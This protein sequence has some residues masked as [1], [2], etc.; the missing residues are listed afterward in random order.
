LIS[1]RPANSTRP[2]R[3][4]RRKAFQPSLAPSRDQ[5]SVASIPNVMSALGRNS[6][7]LELLAQ[8]RVRRRAGEQRMPGRVDLVQEP[9]LGDLGRPNRTAE[10]VVALEHAHAPPGAREQRAA[11]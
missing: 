4:K 7:T 5:S 8:L 10:P 3:P 1:V 9:G 11:D 6:A 2:R